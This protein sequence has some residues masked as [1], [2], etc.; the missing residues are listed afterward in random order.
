MCNLKL[1]IFLFHQVYFAKEVLA[2]L[3]KDLKGLRS[4]RIPNLSIP[5]FSHQGLWHPQ[6]NG[7]QY[8]E[9]Y[10]LLDTVIS[11]NHYV[12]VKIFF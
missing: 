2:D 4:I 1:V 10:I 11:G 6:E 3:D 8:I 9:C 7:F 12:G 5:L